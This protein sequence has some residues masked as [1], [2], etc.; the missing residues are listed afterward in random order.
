MD[1]RKLLQSGLLAAATS[2]GITPLSLAK[3]SKKPNFIFIISDDVSPE[4]LGC[5][6]NK[7]IKTP[8]I[9]LLASMGVKYTNAYLTTASCSPSRNSIITGRY[10]H[11]TGAPE[12]FNELPASQQGFPELL[13]SSGYYTALLGKD[14]MGENAAKGFD[15]FKGTF[16]DSEHGWL[17]LLNQRPMDKPF[18]FW[19]SPVN[20]HLPWHREKLAPLY[21]PSKVII[22][23]YLV[24]TLAMRRDFTNYYHEISITDYYIGELIKGLAAQNELD[25]TYIFYFSDNGRD[26]PR[27]KVALYDSGVKTPLIITGPNINKNSV[28]TGLIS[29]IDFSATVLDLAEL[30]IPESIQGISHK[31]TLNGGLSRNIVFSER[32]WHVNKG[33]ERMVRHGDFTLLKN[34]FPENGSANR[35]TDVTWLPSQITQWIEHYTHGAR[36]PN[37]DF[38]PMNG[39]ELFNVKADPHQLSNLSDIPQYSDTLDSLSNLLNHWE[40]VTGDSLPTNFNEKG[41][42]L[43]KNDLPGKIHNAEF[44]NQKGPY[45]IE[46]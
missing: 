38:Y 26:F 7:A 28:N 19:L 21:E 18:F 20:G 31:E 15:F 17:N 35:V 25:N 13:K 3:S 32:N 8:N 14:H 23:P 46:T 5:Y 24:D 36:L 37:A 6:G 29:S 34:S 11:N 22:P 16:D 40:E 9:D 39:I 2:M 27:C 45:L 42:S 12:L 33:H 41:Q 1:R 43:T 30:S 10:P 4:D 44:I